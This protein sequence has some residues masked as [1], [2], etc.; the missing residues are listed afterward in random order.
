M[1]I[2]LGSGP[3]YLGKKSEINCYIIFLNLFIYFI[4][5]LLNQPI[6]AEPPAAKES[7]KYTLLI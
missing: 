5:Y 6:K 2:D 1:H 7:V 3:I 4:I